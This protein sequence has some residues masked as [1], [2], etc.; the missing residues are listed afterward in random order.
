M[1]THSSIARARTL[2]GG[3]QGLIAWQQ[4]MALAVP[5]RTASEWVASGLLVRVLPRVYSLEHRPAT[6]ERDLFATVLF[7]GPGAML[8]HGTA[9]WWW[10]LI[11]ARPSSQFEVST[12]RHVRP[13]RGIR[14]FG[15]RNLERSVQRGLPV[16]TL[17][18]TVLDL[19]ASQ[20]M[21]LVR[22]AL[23]VL[24]YRHQLE[25]DALA[26]IC[27]QG[28]PGSAALR[29]ALMIHQPRLA[30]TNGPL[31]EDFLIWCER[32]KVP[33]PLVNF[34]VAGIKVDAYW[35]ADAL[36]V[37]LDGGPSHSSRGQRRVDKRKELTLREH[38]IAV[39]RYDWGLLHDEPKR[40]HA[41]L[42]GR[43]TRTLSRDLHEVA[44][45][46]TNFDQRRAGSEARQAASG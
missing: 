37:E 40:I 3:Q 4:L 45:A 24:D 8:S 34:Y 32:Y 5:S 23:A 17:E 30:Y 16:T 27:G 31:E 9:A 26:E 19:A 43:L 18:Q 39:I 20:E 46:G 13:A 15:R 35:P 22:R 41:D 33:I 1:A 38:G 12:S 44:Y 25:L 2:A 6:V 29:R 10:G 28:K 14:V 42:T 7:A 36:V 11:D 21:R